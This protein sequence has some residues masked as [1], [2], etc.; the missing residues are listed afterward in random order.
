MDN[1]NESGSIYE[2]EKN[3]ELNTKK[4]INKK[5]KN[6]IYYDLLEIEQSNIGNK[7][8]DYQNVDESKNQQWRS[9]KEIFN[10]HHKIEEVHY[11][12][13]YFNILSQAKLKGVFCPIQ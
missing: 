7:I 1:L 6:S 4:S 11:Y 3:F 8:F 9:F 10:N 2:E 13:Y 5:N 12:Y